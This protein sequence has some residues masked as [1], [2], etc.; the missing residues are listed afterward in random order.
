M[1]IL[2]VNLYGWVTYSEIGRKY[3]YIPCFVYWVAKGAGLYFSEQIY[4]IERNLYSMKVPGNCQCV[5][6]TIKIKLI[7][8]FSVGSGLT[9][10][11]DWMIFRT[12]FIWGFL[13]WMRRALA[14][15]N[16]QKSEMFFCFQVI[17]WAYELKATEEVGG[18]WSDGLG[19]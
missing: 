4:A 5:Q 2:H 3:I 15:Y 18:W 17:G 14:F 11:V 12:E 1:V 13:W 7:L 9:C 6:Y 16:S 8:S 10:V 19:R